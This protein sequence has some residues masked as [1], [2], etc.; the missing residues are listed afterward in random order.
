M[1][2]QSKR[3]LRAIAFIMPALTPISGFITAIAFG[4]G[5]A[6]GAELLGAI[7]FVCLLGL[8]NAHY[9][10]KLGDLDYSKKKHFELDD[11][12]NR[13]RFNN[14][15]GGGVICLV[16]AI[17]FPLVAGL[18]Y[19]LNPDIK[20]SLLVIFIVLGFL[21]AGLSSLFAYR[22]GKLLNLVSDSPYV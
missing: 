15:I 9:S 14:Y 4:Y 5:Y 21:A 6:G 10:H 2:I 18:G 12:L 3:T 22:A 13:F 7:I 8:T 11:S 1:K 20:M 16:L 19:S 17:I